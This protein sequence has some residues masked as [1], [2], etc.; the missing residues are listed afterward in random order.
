MHLC[1]I[2]A[3]LKIEHFLNVGYFFDF[4]IDLYAGQTIRHT[5]LAWT[6]TRRRTKPETK[7]ETT[8]KVLKRRNMCHFVEKQRVQGY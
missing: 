7:T 2:M 3:F 6:K 8:T 4:L 5:R 1:I